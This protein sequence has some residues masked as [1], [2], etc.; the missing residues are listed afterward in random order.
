M[1][2]RA[3]CPQKYACMMVHGVHILLS[4]WK[5]ST[6]V[7]SKSTS[8]HECMFDYFS[9]VMQQLKGREECLLVSRNPVFVFMLPSAVVH[10]LAQLE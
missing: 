7:K 2:I 8:L 9:F 5:K 1:N 3:R 10:H 4:V 6:V